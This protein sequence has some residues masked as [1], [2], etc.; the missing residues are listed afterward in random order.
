MSKD[1]NPRL[2]V[3]CSGGIGRSGTFLTAFDGF[4]WCIGKASG[5][6]QGELQ[7]NNLLDSDGAINFKE[8]VLNLRKTRHP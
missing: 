2:V 3:H 1:A 6:N 7:M 5:Q 4:D 8:T